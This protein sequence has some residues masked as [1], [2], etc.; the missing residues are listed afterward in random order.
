MAVWDF[1]GLVYHAIFHGLKYAILGMQLYQQVTM[2]EQG[3]KNLMNFNIEAYL[4]SRAMQMVAAARPTY[5]HNRVLSYTNPYVLARHAEKFIG[6]DKIEEKL[7]A[8]QRATSQYAG[9]ETMRRALQ[10]GN[11]H[12]DDIDEKQTRLDGLRTRSDS[13][14]GNLQATQAG[15]ALISEQVASTDNLRQAVMDNSNINA[16]GLSALVQ[17]EADKTRASWDFHQ[18]VGHAPLSVF[19]DHG[20][21]VT[22]EDPKELEE[23]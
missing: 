18:Q 20:R 11:Q 6:L 1:L 2:V 9:L 13:A 8:Q 7:R 22:I 23:L 14:E 17:G 5:Q 3:I 10:V 21:T 12:T 4:Q 16:A 15:N 19:W